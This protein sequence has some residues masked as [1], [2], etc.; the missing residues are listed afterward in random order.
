MSSARCHLPELLNAYGVNYFTATIFD[1]SYREEWL[2]RTGRSLDFTES[3]IL[4]HLALLRTDNSTTTTPHD[5]STR[6]ELLRYISTHPMHAS[7][8]QK[9]TAYF[10]HND[11][12]VY[13]TFAEVKQDMFDLRLAG[14]VDYYTIFREVFGHTC[15]GLKQMTFK[16]TSA[17]LKQIRMLFECDR[18]L[19]DLVYA[20]RTHG[21]GL[22][23]TKHD[24][25]DHQHH[26]TM[27]DD[28]PLDTHTLPSRTGRYYKIWSRL[29]LKEKDERMCEYRLYTVANMALNESGGELRTFLSY[30]EE[31]CALEVDWQKL[32]SS[33]LG[34]FI[35]QES[36]SVDNSS[37][38]DATTKRHQR[39][40]QV[41]DLHDVMSD[42]LLILA[43]VASSRQPRRRQDVLQECMRQ[44]SV[45]V[46]H[47]VQTQLLKAIDKLYLTA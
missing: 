26:T 41:T 43:C 45:F 10:L 25:S 11:R 20:Y 39:S 23:N 42:M 24:T 31:V 30:W 33:K 16:M 3:D 35:Q 44:Y 32:W 27:N 34:M 1:D 21:L 15:N 8:W 6:D 40:K 5:A 36:K 9:L 47:A 7:T 18:R 29:T 12:T 4:R 2:I 13:T 37:R 22:A 38:I 19:A 14:A 28:V 17:Q 46:P